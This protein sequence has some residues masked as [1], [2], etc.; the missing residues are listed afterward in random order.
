MRILL[1]FWQTAQIRQPEKIGIYAIKKGDFYAG[2]Y[3]S[4]F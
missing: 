4:G 2:L 3:K 1:I